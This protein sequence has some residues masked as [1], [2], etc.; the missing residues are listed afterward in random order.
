MKEKLFQ[1]T[2]TCGE[3]KENITPITIE[4]FCEIISES[5]AYYPGETIVVTDKENGDVICRWN[6]DDLKQ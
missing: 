1:A 2:Y 3:I 6:C 5:A 4:K